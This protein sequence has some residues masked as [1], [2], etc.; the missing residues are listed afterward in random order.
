MKSDK[1]HGFCKESA[2]RMIFVLIAAAVVCL[3][4]T[5]AAFCN[6][7]IEFVP[8]TMFAVSNAKL[9]TDGDGVTDTNERKF[10]TKTTVCDTDEDKLS[11]GVELGYIQPE[12]KN[13]CHGLSAAG[14]NYS[15]PHV[16]DP[17]NPDSDNDGLKD[18]EED[19][20]YNGWVDPNETDPSIEDTDGDGLSDYLETTGDFNDDDVPDFDFHLINNGQDCNPPASITDL[21]CDGIPNGRDEDSDEDGC[22][23]KIEG[24][25]NWLDA[26]NNGI[27]AVYD[28]KEQDGCQQESTGGSQTTIPGS[29]KPSEKD[30]S[31]QQTS[32]LR[33]ADDGGACAL[34]EPAA[35]S[36]NMRIQRV[37]GE[38]VLLIALPSLLFGV[39]RRK[40]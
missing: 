15:K 24:A 17:L 6:E 25:H 5:S 35:S 22:S 23:D 29:E 10:G 37:L 39:Y 34:I 30:G 19:E 7:T 13:G 21:D 32:F 8:Y 3:M 18:G 9:D 14:T 33:G 4:D 12:D 16:L 26:N 11:D 31:Q 2:G 20:N 27:P 36:G 38:V 28:A 40:T 1:R